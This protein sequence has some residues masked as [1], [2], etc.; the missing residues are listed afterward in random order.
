MLKIFWLD[1]QLCIKIVFFLLS[2]KSTGGHILSQVQLVISASGSLYLVDL[3][4]VGGLT[5]II[6]DQSRGGGSISYHP[7]PLARPK[8]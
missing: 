2:E 6:R 3:H 5:G 1:S 7:I 4:G 8:A